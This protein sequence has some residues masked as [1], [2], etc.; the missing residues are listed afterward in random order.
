LVLK[1]DLRTNEEGYQ[2]SVPMKLISTSQLPAPVLFF[3]G[4]WNC[5][6]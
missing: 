6:K 1:D 3:K 2:K 5:G 4:D